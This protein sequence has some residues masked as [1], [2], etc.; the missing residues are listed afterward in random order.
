MERIELESLEKLIFVYNADSG[1]FNLLS[2]AA[3]RVVRPS[4]YPCKLCAVTFSFTGMRS[5]WKDFIQSLGY[6][7]EF[8]HRDE[9]AK[10]HAIT[11]VTL[12]AIFAETEKGLQVWITAD[13]INAC[14]SLKDLMSMVSSRLAPQVV[15]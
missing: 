11:D 15:L 9:L 4:T 8:L 6:P 5:E 2:D 1:L 12:P 14:K 3:H 7:T 10:K 13:E